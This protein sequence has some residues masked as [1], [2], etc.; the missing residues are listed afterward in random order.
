MGKYSDLVAEDDWLLAVDGRAWTFGDGVTAQQI[1]ADSHASLAPERAAKHLFPEI[2]PHFVELALPG[3]V[4]VAGLDFGGDANQ[5]LLPQAL[6]AAGVSAVVARSFGHFFFKNCINSGLPALMVEE[7]AA[8]KMGDR[9]RIDVEAHIVANKSS[10]DRYVARS[11][12][13]EE[14]AILRAGDLVAYTRLK[15]NQPTED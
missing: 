2:S 9:L 12:N 6:R 15:Q 4:I 1:L 8:I 7:T 11:I 3:D 10:G 14:L 5:R 13:D